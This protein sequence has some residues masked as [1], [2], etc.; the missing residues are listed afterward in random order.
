MKVLCKSRDQQGEQG[1]GVRDRQAR[2]RGQERFTTWHYQYAILDRFFLVLSPLLFL[3]F[4]TIYWG[5]FRMWHTW[6]QLEQENKK[7]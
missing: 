6:F 1:Q 3:I 7:V 5:Y 2:H 4:N